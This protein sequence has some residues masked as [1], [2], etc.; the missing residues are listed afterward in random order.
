MDKESKLLKLSLLGTVFFAILGISWGWTIKSNMILFDG[1][2]SLIGIVL[3]SASLWVCKIIKEKDSRDFY[4]GKY[5][6]EPV[7]IS[8]NSFVFIVTCSVSIISS[9]N[10]LFSGGNE[11]K[12]GYALLY[13]VVSTIACAFIYFKLN[14]KSKK[15]ISELIKTESVQ[16][17]MDLLLSIS[18]LVG[19]C[20]VV[21]LNKTKYFY[22]SNYVDPGMVLIASVFCIRNPI[23]R[24]V[25]NIKELS[26]LIVP[27]R[28][29]AEVKKSVKLIKK[30]YSFLDVNTKVVKRGR[31]IRIE[32]TFINREDLETITLEDMN[33]IKHLLSDNIDTGRYIKDLEVGF[34]VGDNIYIEITG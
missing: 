16:W 24:F 3:S 33:N 4:F 19:F 12:V 31:S 34:E 11:T 10:S 9:I 30:E 7:V 14:E 2:Y 26:G 1:L 21:I 27:E 20:L 15:N 13:A 29:N 5:I 32:I 18:I 6:L 25:K 8:F 23:K 17:L 28:I 22:L